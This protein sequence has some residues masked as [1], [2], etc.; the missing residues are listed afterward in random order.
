LG[1][2]DIARLV[3]DSDPTAACRALIDAG[4]AAGADDNVTVAVVHA[5]AGA[6]R[7][8][9]AGLGATLRRL[10]GRSR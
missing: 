9:A 1:D 6:L 8:K 3:T 2:A 7:P 4:L 10:V 5:G